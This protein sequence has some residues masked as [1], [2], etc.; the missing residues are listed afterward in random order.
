MWSYACNAVGMKNLIIVS[1]CQ[2][3]VRYSPDEVICH[4]H[5]KGVCAG[6]LVNEIQLRKNPDQNVLKGSEYLMVVQ[7]EAFEEGVLRGKI[8]KLK[9]LEE[10]WDRS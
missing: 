9:P 3:I 6:E 4:F 1:K 5:F 10:C 7:F 2:R 8:I